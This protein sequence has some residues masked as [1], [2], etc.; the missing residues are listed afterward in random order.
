MGTIYR[1]KE[2]NDKERKKVYWLAK[3]GK[4][5]KRNKGVF[6]LPEEDIEDEMYEFQKK[7]NKCVYCNLNAL[8][9][10]NLGDDIPVVY[11]VMLSNDS[12]ISCIKNKAGFQVYQT[13]RK[14]Y[15]LGLTVVKTHYG[16]EVVVYDKEKTLCDI[17]RPN[18]RVS[19][20]TVIRAYRDYFSNGKAKIN[21]LMEYARIMKIE[22]KVRPYAEVL[23][24]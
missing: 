9:L 6:T 22:D 17:M 7:Y 8:Y 4:L 12:N 2:L 16:N 14:Y 15:E 3:K 11:D 21:K 1:T 19:K 20:E 18:S 5:I 13:N 23:Q 10:W 24:C